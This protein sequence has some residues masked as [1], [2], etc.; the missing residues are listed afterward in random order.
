M[1]SA[2]SLGADRPFLRVDGQRFDV[3]RRH[4]LAEFAFDQGLGQETDEVEEEQGLDSA[5]VLQ[6]DRGDL[7]HRLC[8]L[9]ALLNPR[10]S[11]VRLE[12]CDGTE[13]TVIRNQGVERGIS[14]W[15][16]GGSPP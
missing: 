3:V 16:C 11:L 6:E 7:V 9:E 8:L 10:L 1:R 13:V 4:R 5:L 15:R 2:Q 14:S 12:D